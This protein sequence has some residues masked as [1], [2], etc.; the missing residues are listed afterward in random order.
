[1]RYRAMELATQV[2]GRDGRKE[3]AQ[4]RQ[5]AEA[6]EAWVTSHAKAFRS[7]RW[8]DQPGEISSAQAREL[9]AALGR[10]PQVEVEGIPWVWE[11]REQGDERMTCSHR[12]QDA[13]TRG[14][15]VGHAPTVAPYIEA[16]NWQAMQPGHTY[17]CVACEEQ[18][19]T[20]EAGWERR[21]ERAMEFDEQGVPQ[22]RDEWTVF[23]LTFPTGTQ[24]LYSSQQ[25]VEDEIN[26]ASEIEV[27]HDARWELMHDG[28]W[29]LLATSER[30]AMVTL[31]VIE[32]DPQLAEEL[33]ARGFPEV[34]ECDT[35]DQE[36]DHDEAPRQEGERS[37]EQAV[38]EPPSN[39]FT[40]R[41]REYFSR[42]R[43]LAHDRGHGQ[44]MG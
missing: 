2:L 43:E 1:M 44:G 14:Q 28:G 9:R 17:V 7:G 32:G 8:D 15:L 40:Q 11:W 42:A 25:L 12:W 29:M 33:D 21:G 39:G 35:F 3:R 31:S 24:A 18:I 6:L 26:A 20:P 36:F 27:F 37:A 16:G 22:P 23:R 30:G 34:Q 13:Q 41:L 5:T 19:T 4:S 38:S 10:L